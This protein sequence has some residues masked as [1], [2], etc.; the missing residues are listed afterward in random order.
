[1][2]LIDADKIDFGEVFKGS[3]DFAKDIRETAQEFIDNQPTAYDVNNVME[4]LENERNPMYRMDG[5]L[6]SERRL[7]KIDKAVEIVKFGGV[8]G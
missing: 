2:R 5:S 7:I 6:M 4:R 1:M 3:S 8:I